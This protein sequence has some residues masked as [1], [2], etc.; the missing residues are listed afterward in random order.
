MN[1]WMTYVKAAYEVI[2]MA[3]SKSSVILDH[4]TEAFVVHTFARY[5]EQPNIPTDVIA[6]KMMTAVSERGEKQKHA[7]Q[8]IAEEC[9]LINGL[10][11]NSRR[12]PTKNYYSDMG[13]LAL[14]HRAW[15]DRPPELLYEK[16]AYQFDN[17]SRMLHSI[18][19]I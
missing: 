7:F 16:I 13:K 10:E 6:I 14:E 5:M 4:E 8:Q 19:H 3:E 11:L 2:M 1:H 9:L 12:W 15:V 18:R 17:I